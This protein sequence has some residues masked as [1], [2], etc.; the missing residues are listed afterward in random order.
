MDSLPH[1]NIDHNPLY[2]KGNNKVVYCVECRCFHVYYETISIDLSKSGIEALVRTLQDYHRKYKRW[3]RP[4]KRCV[5]V[6]T[7]HRGIRMNLSIHDLRILASML[8]EANAELEKRVW[9]Q[10]LN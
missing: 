6:E 10:N 1:L 2:E 4:D 3:V 5:N 8:I 9:R 7:P